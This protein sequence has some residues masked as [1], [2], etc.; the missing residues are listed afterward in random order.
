MS[1]S[2]SVSSEVIIN[3]KIM[4]DKI[5]VPEGGYWLN[6]GS[7]QQGVCESCSSEMMNDIDTQN[8]E[9][10]CVSVILGATRNNRDE[11]SKI[12]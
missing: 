3:N 9:Y 12:F 1:K 8:G 11:N 7:L 6:I 10:E 4:S 2:E 5:Q